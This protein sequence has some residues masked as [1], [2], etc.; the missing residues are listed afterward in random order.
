MT[1]ARARRKGRGHRPCLVGARRCIGNSMR[2]LLACKQPEVGRPAWCTAAWRFRH[3][4]ACKVVLPRFGATYHS[5]CSLWA[6]TMHR[7]AAGGTQ[8]AVG[9]VCRRPHHKA[10]GRQA[11]CGGG[12][13][14][15][16]MTDCQLQR[17][18]QHNIPRNITTTCGCSAGWHPTC[19]GPMPTPLP[20][21][22][23]DG[24]LRPSSCRTG[25]GP[26]L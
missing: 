4:R 23:P 3:K 8:P 26:P 24:P 20:E 22:Q 25:W 19:Q 11:E 21:C 14:T 18:A 10:R 2:M 13:N 17:A 9:T 5:P 16:H 15:R 12:P 7:P 1:Y 6:T